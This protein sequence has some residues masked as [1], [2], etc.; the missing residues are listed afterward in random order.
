MTRPALAALC[1]L[2][3]VLL[4]LAAQA[5]PPDF[6]ER[7][8]GFWTVRFDSDAAGVA[9]LEQLPDDV[10]LIDDAGGGELAA[11]EFS[12]LTLS[13]SALAAARNYDYSTELLP[14]NACRAPSV[15]FYMQAPFPMEIHAGRDLIVF[16]MEYFDLYRVVFM[17]GRPHPPADAPHTLSG[18]SV[19]RWEGD[20]LVV[21][22]THIA[23]GTFMNNGF[24]HSPDL[25][26]TE[27]FDLGEDASVLRLVQVYEDPE[28]FEGRAARYMSWSKRPGEH[29]LPYDC[30]PNYGG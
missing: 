21:D 30:D 29:V 26:L 17:D 14:E 3:Q 8:S 13:E 11:G 12:G 20:A 18:H 10:V 6:R 16:R 19:G 4:P 7:W 9:L 22:T 15:A 27:R 5:Q 28:T 24:D 1:L 23:P 2:A 25:R